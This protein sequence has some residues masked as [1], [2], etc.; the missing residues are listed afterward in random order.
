MIRTEEPALDQI[1]G[2]HVTAP[3]VDLGRVHAIDRPDRALLVLYAIRSLLY[4]AFLAFIPLYFRYHSLRYRFD[5]HGVAITWGI[6]F[7]TDTFLTYQKIQDIH[8]TRSWLER[9]LGIGTVEIQTASSTRGAV[10][11]LVGLRDF[12]LVR[13]FLYQSMRGHEADESARTPDADP[14]EVLVAIRD[15]IRGLRSDVEGRAQ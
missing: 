4:S 5:E 6:L 2:S 12:E 11:S 3:R 14:L 13:D 9:L 10:E 15:E 8:L 7:R 1:Q